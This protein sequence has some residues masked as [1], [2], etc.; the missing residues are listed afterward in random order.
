MFFSEVDPEWQEIQEQFQTICILRREGRD[1]EAM[2]L[3]ENRL[4]PLLANWTNSNQEEGPQKRARLAH[5]FE[6]EIKRVDDAWVTKNLLDE[7]LLKPFFDEL[8][9]TLAEIKN[10]HGQ[11]PISSFD[12]TEKL[13]PSATAMDVESALEPIR[14][15]LEHLKKTIALAQLNTPAPDPDRDAT[16]LH[17]LL[18]NLHTASQSRED[19][20]MATSHAMQQAISTLK[21]QLH[22]YQQPHLATEIAEI[23]EQMQ[24]I[25]TASKDTRSSPTQPEIEQTLQTACK[26]ALRT[27]LAQFEQHVNVIN[28]TLQQHS[29]LVLDTLNRDQAKNEHLHT[30]LVDALEA[31]FNSH[32]AET[33]Q[34]I[35]DA[36]ATQATHE[37]SVLDK[38]NE[39]QQEWILR[40]GKGLR[41]E[42]KAMRKQIHSL[43]ADHIHFK[44]ANEVGEPPYTSRP[45]ARLEPIANRFKTADPALELSPQSASVESD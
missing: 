1:Q 6:E 43:R 31:A 29:N 10:H 24:Q 16:A 26:E 39:A 21:E 11:H 28:S 35:Q 45:I 40:I 23:K 32:R 30:Q 36:F 17:T 27:A 22:A 37:C 44:Q 2:Q 20:L 41:A 15:E 13:E 19:D 38:V 25:A 5:L 18:E 7:R 14:S 34:I 33:T 8:K 42:M 4:S 3:M 12:S 9:Q